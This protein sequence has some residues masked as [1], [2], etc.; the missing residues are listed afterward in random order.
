MMKK[1]LKMMCVLAVL[2]A[3]VLASCDDF[4]STS[5]GKPRKYDVSKITL[6]QDNLKQW[7]KAAIGN[8]ELAQALVKKIIEEL[9][10]KSGAEKAEFQKVGVELAIEQSGMGVKIL[11]LAGSELSDIDSEEGV[12][13]LLKKVQSGVDTAAAANIAAIV[14]KSTLENTSPGGTPKFKS[15]DPYGTSAD[16]SNVGLAVM[17]LAL[18]VITN[19]NEGTKLDELNNNLT[20][21]TDNPPLVKIVSGA[22]DKEIALAAYLNLIASD[23]SG[24]FDDNPITSAIKSAFGLES[25]GGGE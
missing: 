10:G 5:W 16:P 9:D 8:P 23:T 1:K 22:S 15:D 4:Y 12:K 18:D 17:V 19:I 24:K 2:G 7:K 3:F 11:Q 13:N 6:T 20:L 21:T 14:N 25:S